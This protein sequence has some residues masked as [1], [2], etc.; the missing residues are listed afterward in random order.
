[1]LTGSLLDYRRR[2]GRVVPVWLQPDAARA[3]DAAQGL[4]ALVK[5]FVGKPRGELEQALEDAAPEG[6]TSKAAQGLTKLLLDE[7]EFAVA[8]ERDPLALR[9]ELFGRAAARWR[10]AGHE[11]FADWRDS[12][13]AEVGGAQGLAAAEV[14]AA[15]FAD[16]PD[17]QRLVSAPGWSPEA[18]LHRYNVAQV[19]GLLLG[20]ERLEI[21]AGQ[22][23]P[24]R[25]RQLLRYLKFFGLLFR[26]E[27]DHARDGLRL[28]VD[29]PL[30]VLEGGKGYGLNL[31]AFLPALLLWLPPWRLRASIRLKGGRG[32]AA[33]PVTH[34]LIVEPDPALRSHY[35]DSGQW[36]PDGVRH[37]VERFNAAST[38]WHAELADELIALPGNRYLVPDF[39]IAPADSRA[40]EPPLLLEH[41][42]YP[43]AAVVASK[44][45]LAVQVAGARYVIAC[46]GLPSIGADLRASPH[47]FCYRRQLL[48]AQ[49]NEWLA[50][51]AVN[52][53]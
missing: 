48:A 11:G 38:L 18:L 46:K 21:E 9:R 16:L 1:M 30:S 34:E 12:L 50:P 6:L 35:V 4:I 32:G 28:M 7:A 8:G 23:T 5:T 15:L 53:V 2:K 26:I 37:F 24:A 33:G 14:P 43:S 22:P 10:S 31:A 3:R 20:A 39:R 44:L 41:L 47:L 19:Q 17:M 51:A 40:A 27:R 52:P 29:G 25:L 49:V 45:A 13:L 42:P 36:L